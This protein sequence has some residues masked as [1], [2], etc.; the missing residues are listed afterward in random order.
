MHILIKVIS[1]SLNILSPETLLYC[2]SQI[3]LIRS[4]ATKSIQIKYAHRWVSINKNKIIA[5][6]NRIN[7]LF[8][9]SSRLT[10]CSSKGVL[11]LVRFRLAGI[12]SRQ[13]NTGFIAFS[14]D[15]PFK[16]ISY[17]VDAFENQ[18]MIMTLINAPCGSKSIQ[19]H[20]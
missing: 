12:R 6:F 1:S 19:K 16:R 2:V 15:S 10:F 20:L 9:H 13:L 14:K 3:T 8:K 11:I 18:R 17:I 4:A 7:F 5:V